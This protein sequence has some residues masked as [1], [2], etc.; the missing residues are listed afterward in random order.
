MAKSEDTFGCYSLEGGGGIVIQWVEGRGAAEHPTG[1]RTTRHT[2]ELSS[3]KYQGA[4]KRHGCEILDWEG[5]DLK[6]LLITWP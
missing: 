6:K 1:P 5:R 3:R 4:G 2:K